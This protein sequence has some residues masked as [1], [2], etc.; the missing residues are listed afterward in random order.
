MKSLGAILKE[1]F[2][3]TKKAFLPVV[4]SVGL[5]VPVKAQEGVKQEQKEKDKKGLFLSVG[6]TQFNDEGMD[7]YWGF[8]YPLGAGYQNYYSNNLRYKWGINWMFNR[9]DYEQGNKTTG[10]E[11]YHILQTSAL[12]EL[13]MPQEGF[14]LYFGGGLA[15]SNLWYKSEFAGE[16][17]DKE[18]FEGSGLKLVAGADIPIKPSLDAF[19]QITYDVI[20]PYKMEDRTF[21]MG[22]KTFTAGIRF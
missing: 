16:E 22:G 8:G 2:D 11:L 15:W 20:K 6:G 7:N 4:L 17:P 14:D 13:V 19:I 9:L 21:D 5:L 18:K 10:F 3:Y 12:L 1:G